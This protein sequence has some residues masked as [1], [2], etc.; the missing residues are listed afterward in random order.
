MSITII[1]ARPG[2]YVA[3]FQPRIAFGDGDGWDDHLDLMPIVAWEIER[4]ECLGKI[5]HS[6]QPLT[7]DGNMNNHA[8]WWAIKT[9]EGKYSTP[10]GMCDDEAEAIDVLKQ[11]YGEE[12]KESAMRSSPKMIRSGS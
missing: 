7:I 2:W 1:A 9:P 10:D 6:V 12:L 11:V 4:E 3:M 5:S 8:K